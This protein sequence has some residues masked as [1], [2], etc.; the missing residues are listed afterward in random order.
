MYA[1]TPRSGWVFAASLTWALSACGGGDGGSINPPTP[2]PT[3]TIG[4]ALS[5]ASGTVSGTGGTTTTITLTRGGGFT[6]AVS[7]AMEGAPNGV[8]SAF[9]PASL[10]A[11][12]SSSALAITVGAGAA[13][14]TY[15]LTIRAT[16]TGLSAV[17]ATYTLTVQAPPV[18]DFTIGVNPGTV[19]IE[20]GQSGTA[21]VTI[22]RTGG[23]AGAVGFTVTG[24]PVGVGLEIAPN[25]TTGNSSVLTI[26]VPVGVAAGTYPLVIIGAENGPLSRTTPLSLII[27][28]KP[29]A[30]VLTLSPASISVVQGQSAQVAV[31]FTRATGVTGDVT[32]SVENVLAAITTSF[33][34]NSTSG[35]SSTLTVNVALSQPPG[36]ITLVV[37]ATVGNATTTTTL[38][39]GTS[40]FTP[41]DFSLSAAPSALAVTAG[42][43]G[44]ANIGITRTGNYAGDVSLSASGVPAGVS[45][46]FTPPV[47][48]G[49]A[50]TM[51][52]IATGGAVPGTYPLV[53]NA[54]G[55]G[56]TGTRTTNFT[57]TVNSFG[58]GSVQ[59]RFCDP[60]REPVWFG[61]REGAGAWTQVAKGANVTY[62][63]PLAGNGQ[64]A[65]V[66][67]SITGF[68]VAV[69][70]VTPQ[71][72]LQLAADE[73]AN[74]P[75][76]KSFGGTVTGH[77][78][79][80]SV[81]IAAGGTFT[82]APPMTPGFTLF[83]AGDGVTDLL[84]MTGFVENNQFTTL[85]FGIIR[86]DI[87][88]AAGS[89]VP[90]LDFSSGSSERFS[91][92]AGSIAFQNA[93]GEAFFLVQNYLTSNGRVGAFKAGLAS[94][95]TTRIIH[96]VPD[97]F[98][99]AGDL[100]EILVGTD[101][102]TAPRQ[103]MSYV[104][105]IFT[106]SSP[107]FGPLL[108]QPTVTV[109]GS[110]PVRL[111]ATGTWQSEYN[112][113]GAATFQQTTGARSVVITASRTALGG[114]ATYT[115]EIPDFSGA[116]GWNPT[117]M[118]QPGV[119]TSHTISL[120]GIKSG[121]TVLPANGTELIS[122]QR[123]GTITP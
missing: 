84:A 94:T 52:I 98:R 123:V 97:A 109:L 6:G 60:A 18:P 119:S 8:T 36:V 21:T 72:A 30:G 87:N 65:Y 59:W 122:A 95:E 49:N 12:N 112:W 43:N 63:V 106:L 85:D 27:Q 56:I 82:I 54:A 116:P 38:Q 91:V 88:P 50:S 24:V 66:I 118:L 104:S 11:G 23:Y 41:Q 93:G 69:F 20:E 26:S 7:L 58:G 121:A 19:T 3:G 10:A 108:S 70:A 34:P 67:P 51:N 120:T 113:G 62:N 55:T 2:P 90:V 45:V 37:R 39:V 28:P 64:V 99:R 80:R 57:L 83:S 101:N 103:L 74:S 102:L 76:R 81:V 15:P 13:P 31:T 117:W 111:R 48:D 22:A 68:D 73:C 5:N 110:T 25:N 33:S 16:A 115:F 1:R 78:A 42:S 17:T 105:N 107:S 4:I 77:P 79:S 61:V 96:G 75:A 46:G 40:A 47:T 86:R 35:N 89:T 44:Q 100:H 53:I 9:T 29:S 71:E 114:G 14:G 32:F 92:S